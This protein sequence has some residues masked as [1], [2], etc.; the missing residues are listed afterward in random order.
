[1]ARERLGVL[2]NDGVTYETIGHRVNGS[3]RRAMIQYGMTNSEVARVL[4]D[5]DCDRDVMIQRGSHQH[6]FRAL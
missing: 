6:K 3:F 1:M 5:I 4:P 2:L